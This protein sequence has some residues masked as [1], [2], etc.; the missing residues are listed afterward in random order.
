M[1][2]TFL[3]FA[4]V[5]LGLSTLASCGSDDHPQFAPQGDGGPRIFPEVSTTDTR[6]DGDGA[7]DGTSDSATDS[8]ADGPATDTTVSDA[9]AD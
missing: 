7:S 3:I 6:P 8:T 2:T 9:P 5:A 4:F 1:R